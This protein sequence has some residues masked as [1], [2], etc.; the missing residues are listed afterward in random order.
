MKKDFKEKLDLNKYILA[1]FDI[2]TDP[3]KAGRKPEPFSFGFYTGAQTIEGFTYNTS[4]A[5]LEFFENWEKL[6]KEEKQANVNKYR[7]AKRRQQKTRV[8]ND[9]NIPETYVDFWDNDPEIVKAEFIN[10]L[11][12]LDEPH[13]IFAHNGGKF[14][15]MYFH[16]WIRGKV[17]VINGRLVEWEYITQKGVKHILR[18]SYAILPVALGTGG[19]KLDMDYRKMEKANRNKHKE[20]ILKYLKQ[21]CVALYDLCLAFKHKYDK[22]FLTLASASYSR[23]KARYKIENTDFIYDEMYRQFYF[24]GRCQAFNSGEITG[25][26]EVYDVNSMYP[27]AMSEYNHPLSKNCYIGDDITEETFF[28]KWSGKNYGAVPSRLKNGEINFDILEGE[29]F[30]SIHEYNVALKYNLIEVDEVIETH[31][32]VTY[33]TFKEHIDDCKEAKETAEKGSK[34]YILAKLDMNS[35]YGKFAQ[36]PRKYKNY[37][38][39][40]PDDE[41]TE[42]NCSVVEGENFKLI[43]TPDDEEKRFNNVA[44]AASITGASRA[45]MLEGLIEFTKAGAKVFYCD[46]DSIICDK[47]KLK[48]NNL[49]FHESELGAWDK[50]KTGDTVYIGGKKIYALF[51][52]DNCVKIASKGVRVIPRDIYNFLPEFPDE[53]DVKIAK[54]D[55][56]NIGGDEI[57]RVAMGGEF[58][59]KNDAPS[60]K[61]DG[62]HNFV[63][64]AMTSTFKQPTL[65]ELYQNVE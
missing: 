21:D 16:A 48:V 55:M 49:K 45:M 64:R 25:D 9:N 24:G 33:G 59:F 61:L 11:E 31:N 54:Q 41:V 30:T 50:E 28:I 62:N 43:C 23:I 15:Y 52:N 6:T 38:F 34:Q 7:S 19:D 14:D 42:N 17:F 20:E 60:L 35:G 10:H 26:I 58:I 36:D 29:F 51:K 46:T 3:F 1:T 44:T 53:N 39:V 18:D 27:Y 57:K 65:L 37:E 56:L 2:E 5:D 32:W 12:S 40:D 4:E 13:L 8:K 47:P 22:W 63:E